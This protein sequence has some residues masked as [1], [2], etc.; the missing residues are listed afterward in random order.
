[1]ESQ[2]KPFLPTRDDLRQWF[3][4]ARVVAVLAVIVVVIL[5]VMQLVGVG[6]IEF[7][8]GDSA[9]TGECSYR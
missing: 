3:F 8:C 4:V 2:D 9:I 1:M 6:V 7:A 5:G